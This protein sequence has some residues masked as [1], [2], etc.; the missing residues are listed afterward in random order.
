MVRYRRHR[1]LGGLL[2][3]AALIAVASPAAAQA[4]APPIAEFLVIWT[5]VLSTS[6]A[7]ADDSQQLWV[8]GRG[9]NTIVNL[10]TAMFDIGRYGFDS[11][12]W[13]ALPAG[14]AP[15]EVQAERFLRFIQQPDNQPAHI[16]SIAR[17]TRATMVALLRYAVDAWSLETALAEGVRLN[18]GAALSLQQVEWLRA[19]AATH[20]PGSHRRART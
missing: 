2:V 3:L 7:A 15:T 18:L 1:R 9:V 5:G 10:D 13:V 6:Q 11:F 4:P 17:D 16:S 12:L 14:T 20:P 8:R 19:W